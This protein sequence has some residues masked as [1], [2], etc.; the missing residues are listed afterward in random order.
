MC[1]L[2]RSVSHVRQKTFV[3]G[4]LSAMLTMCVWLLAFGMYLDVTVKRRQLDLQQLS[5]KSAA[6]TT[7]LHWQTVKDSRS[8]ALSAFVDR[9]GKVLWPI[10]H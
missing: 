5:R 1:R 4:F 9:R 6:Y 7:T 2:L 8:Y 10:F 3:F